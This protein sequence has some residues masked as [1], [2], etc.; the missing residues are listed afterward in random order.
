[1]IGSTYI[2][3]DN[4]TFRLSFFVTTFS[5][6]VPTQI[7]HGWVMNYGTWG[8]FLCHWHTSFKSNPIQLKHTHT[9]ILPIMYQSIHPFIHPPPSTDRPSEPIPSNDLP[10]PHHTTPHPHR[11]TKLIIHPTKKKSN[12]LLLL[13][14]CL[15]LLIRLLLL[16]SFFLY[17]LIQ[18]FLRTINFG[19]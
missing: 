6:F 11:N 5:P 18:Q 4:V 3:N 8:S 1:V 10:S 16:Q 2:V 17:I 14:C 12:I 9:P 13:L 7:L 19:L 15:L